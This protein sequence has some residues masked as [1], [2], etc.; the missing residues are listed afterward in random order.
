MP[1]RATIS[2]LALNSD[3][4]TVGQRLARLRKERGFTQV[5]L[6]EQLGT[7]QSLITAYETDRRALSAEMAV[8]LAIALDVSTD[9]LLHPKAAK[10][11]TKKPSLKIVRRMEQIE[12]LPD[13][14]QSF[15]L[16]ALDSMLRGAASR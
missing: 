4:E 6:A 14:K 15:I 5:G 10:K 7:R 1:K 11:K 2:K 12:Q 13:N 16:S 3:G 8:Q 9:D